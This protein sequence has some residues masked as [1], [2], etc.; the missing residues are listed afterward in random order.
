MN[1]N[2]HL[3]CGGCGKLLVVIVPEGQSRKLIVECPDRI[4]H[5][6]SHT[7]IIFD[8]QWDERLPNGERD[9]R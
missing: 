2:S 4:E 7:K 1:N 9:I 3:A 5:D 8:L 6:E